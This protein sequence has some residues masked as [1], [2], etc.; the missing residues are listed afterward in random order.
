MAA[1]QCGGGSKCSFKAACHEGGSRQRS[2]AL[3]S[4][5]SRGTGET[6]V[7]VRPRMTPPSF[8][9]APLPF[10]SSLVGVQVLV[11]EA[12]RG[13][14]REVCAGGGYR[15]VLG[16]WYYKERIGRDKCCIMSV[17]EGASSRGEERERE[18]RERKVLK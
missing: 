18:R 11:R 8:I 7:F 14:A 3:F 10:T 13:R 12:P 15:D 5:V 16:K 4:R 6:W 9:S 2:V 1:L 17:P